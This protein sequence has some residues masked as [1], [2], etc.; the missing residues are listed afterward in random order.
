[1]PCS[2]HPLG[3]RFSRTLIASVFPLAVALP[4]WAS[5]LSFERALTLATRG[6]LVFSAISDGTQS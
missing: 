5:P 4:L 6:P 1:M 3:H 2:V